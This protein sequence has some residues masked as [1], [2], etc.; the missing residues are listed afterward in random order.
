[1][2][3]LVNEYALVKT[4]GSPPYAI[5]LE[6]HDILKRI[7]VDPA[8]FGGKPIIRGM[9]FSVEPILLILRLL[10]QGQSWEDLLDDYPDLAGDDIRACPAYAHAAIA[11]DSLDTV[12][13]VRK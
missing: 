10:A 11:N 2:H 9:R 3:A 6:H 1:L 12:E 8:I 5:A 7:T 13:V 4:R